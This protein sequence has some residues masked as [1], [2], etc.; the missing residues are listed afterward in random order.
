MSLQRES[1]VNDDKTLEDD[2]HCTA[3]ELFAQNKK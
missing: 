3:V 2:D 1:E